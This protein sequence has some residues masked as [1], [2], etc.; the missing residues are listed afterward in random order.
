[1]A[2]EAAGFFPVVAVM[3]VDDGE[4]GDAHIHHHSANGADVAGALRLNEYD[5]NI[6]E[7][8]HNGEWNIGTMEDWNVGEGGGLR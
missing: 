6:F 4:V 5:A 7:W 3:R 1:M 8:V 2:G